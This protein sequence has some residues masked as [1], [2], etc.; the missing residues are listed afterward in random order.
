MRIFIRTKRAQLHTFQTHSDLGAWNRAVVS[1]PAAFHRE[2]GLTF[3]A[4]LEVGADLAN[5]F[6]VIAAAGDTH[7]NSQS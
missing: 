1:E 4:A 7:G 6:I 3:P 2:A 5:L